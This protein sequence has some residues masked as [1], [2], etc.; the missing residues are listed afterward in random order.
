MRENRPVLPLRHRG[1]RTAVLHLGPTN[2][3]KTHDSVVAL[4]TAGQGVYAA[5]L[6]QLAHEAYERLFELR[7][8]D[9]VG[10]ST[11]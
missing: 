4:A 7:G 8:P 3:G 2:S 11:V 9:S 10:L 6:R 5:P 1:P